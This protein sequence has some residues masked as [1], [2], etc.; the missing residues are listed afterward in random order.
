MIKFNVRTKQKK[1]V[2][3]F[4]FF[5][6]LFAGLSFNQTAFAEEAPSPAAAATPPAIAEVTSTGGP[7]VDAATRIQ[8]LGGGDTQFRAAFSTWTE[9]DRGEA[10]VA[11]PSRKPIDR[12]T[13]SSDFGTRSDPFSGRRA[14]HNGIDIPAPRG[15][16][17]FAT[18]DGTIGRAQW[19][20]GYGKYVEI[21]HGANIQTRYG[22]MAEYI[23]SSGQKVRKGDII[24][25]VGST[26]RSTGNHLHYE[27]RL[28]GVPV[29]PMN[30]VQTSE[31]LLALRA[32][33]PVN[34]AIAPQTSPTAQ[35]GPVAK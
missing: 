33:S 35:G 16:P 14:R 12:M 22:H 31:M 13:L 24:G 10:A 8:A 3:F 34:V 20:S 2:Q 17:I 4:A 29:N 28:S 21:N 7:Y 5:S 27:V 11:I 9:I 30:F 15:T 23:V 1:T 19:V 18:A 6:L 32:G 26:G 25:Y